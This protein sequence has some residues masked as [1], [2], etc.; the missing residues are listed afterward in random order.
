MHSRFS[1][2]LIAA[3]LLVRTTASAQPGAQPSKPQVEPATHSR[4]AQLSAQAVSSA[5]KGDCAAVR[6]ADLQ[7]R[8]IDPQYHREV[9]AADS[10]ISS[11]L[12]PGAPSVP[13]EIRRLGAVIGGTAG[14]GGIPPLAVIAQGELLVGWM[15]HPR[16][17]LLLVGAFGSVGGIEGNGTFTGLLGGTRVWMTDRVFLD[18]RIGQ[19]EDTVVWAIGLGTEVK[20]AR[21]SSFDL[22]LHVLAGDG[23][24]LLIGGIGVSWY[25]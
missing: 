1:A 12:V 11:C 24:G 4:A 25:Q 20:H 9:F 17:A 23:A 6:T 22:H 5:R 18:G 8:E 7:I 13:E 16:I 2:I 10:M 19:I 3:S 21:H 14:L 15:A